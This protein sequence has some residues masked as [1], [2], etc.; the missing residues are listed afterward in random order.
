MPKILAQDENK[1][2]D[3]KFCKRLPHFTSVLHRFLQSAYVKREGYLEFISTLTEHIAF[4]ER[5]VDREIEVVPNLQVIFKF[6]D[7]F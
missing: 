7:V 5:L 3:F 2:P 6:I 4:F 1:I